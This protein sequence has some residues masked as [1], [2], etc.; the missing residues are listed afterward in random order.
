MLRSRNSTFV[1]ARN[2]KFVKS[3]IS[4][5]FIVEVRRADLQRL[6][7][8]SLVESGITKFLARRFEVIISTHA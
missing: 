2:S 3:R 7:Q 8:G 6:L 5:S 1:R 4:L